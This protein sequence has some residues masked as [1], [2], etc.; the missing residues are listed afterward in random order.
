MIRTEDAKKIMD[1][2]EEAHVKVVIFLPES[3]LKP[4]YSICLL[5]TSDAADEL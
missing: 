2:L 3:R 5:Y 1:A 4:L